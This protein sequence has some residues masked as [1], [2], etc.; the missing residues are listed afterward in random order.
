MTGM[1]LRIS[2]STL[3]GSDPGRLDSPPTS[4]MST[5]AS[6]I[7]RPAASASFCV[8]ARLAGKKESGGA[9]EDAHDVSLA[10]KVEGP[11]PPAHDPRA[12]RRLREELVGDGVKPVRLALQPRRQET[13]HVPA[14]GHDH[15]RFPDG[16]VQG[17]L[18]HG[19][20]AP[21]RL[22]GRAYEVRRAGVHP[23][24]L[25]RAVKEPLREP[26]GLL[27]GDVDVAE[28]PAKVGR[29]PDVDDVCVCR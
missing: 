28:V 23:L 21:E 2:S 1:T 11:V 13:E 9:V 25:H 16:V 27:V 4:M 24:Q 10:G 8:L 6:I 5:P 18:A 17:L 22:H 7:S 26:S 12:I 19:D 3:T 20:A 14:A 29:G 15:V